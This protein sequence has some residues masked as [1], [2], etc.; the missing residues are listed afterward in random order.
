[1][2]LLLALAV[3]PFRRSKRVV[4]IRVQR[5]PTAGIALVFAVAVLPWPVAVR[6]A[7]AQCGGPTPTPAPSQSIV[8]L[9]TDHLG[10]TQMITSESGE[11]LEHVRYMP[12]GE[13]RGRWDGNGTLLGPFAADE[14]PFGFTGHE[15]EESSGLI[16]AGARF[17]DPELASFL[18]PDPAGEFTSPYSYVG[19]D[20]VNGNDPTGECE[21]LCLL[22]VTALVGFLLG[23]AEAALAGA[24]LGEV[25]KAGLISGA[26]SVVGAA[27]L[28]PAGSA[29]ESLD[30]WGRAVSG[31]IRLAGAGYGIYTTVEAFRDGEYVAGARGALQILS[32]AFGGLSDSDAG[33]GAKQSRLP[34]LAS[35]LTDG[36]PVTGPATP[37]M[38]TLPNN[39]PPPPPGG[40]IARIRAASLTIFGIKIEVG[41]AWA[42]DSAGNR[43]VFDVFSIGVESEVVEV[44]GT[45]GLLISDAV[46]VDDLAG[47]S[48]SIGGSGGPSWPAFGAEYT[49]GDNYSGVTLYSGATYGIA[50]IGAYGIK[51]TWTPRSP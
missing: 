20:P 11:I 16:Y 47:T 49:V 19:W 21:L 29:L 43:R 28:G 42:I 15:L 25:L 41:T 3:V 6:P 8:H 26:T 32:A 30:G 48:T 2:L 27:V 37:R 38:S 40:A 35:F 46:Q 39:F 13:V 1:L 33:V 50:P 51:E 7:A 31:A 22:A 10:S 9:H 12:Y 23:A 44:T 14:S 45:E 34:A 24:D 36:E 17:Y 5:G 18:T 4:G